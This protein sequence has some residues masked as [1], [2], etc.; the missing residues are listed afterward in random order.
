L[1]EHYSWRK[2][3]GAVPAPETP[4]VTERLVSVR[5]LMRFGGCLL[6]TALTVGAAY[7]IPAGAA[8]VPEAK[9]AATGDLI[10][11]PAQS[12][13]LTLITGDRFIV[14][15]DGLSVTPVPVPG[16]E[17]MQYLTERSGG[18]LTV[19]PV[20][21]VPLV[22]AGTVD[23]RLF[24]VTALMQA[25]HDDSRSALPLIVSYGGGARGEQK[26]RTMVA[27]GEAEVVHELPSIGGIAVRQDQAQL[28]ELW[29]AL[30]RPAAAVSTLALEAGVTRVA[31][32]GVDEL[33]LDASVP[34]IGAPAL[35]ADGFTGKGVKIGLIDSGIDPNHPDLAGRVVAQDFTGTGLQDD[36]GHGTHVAST[37]AGN[38]AASGGRYKGVAPDATIYSAKACTLGGCTESAILRS[39]EWLSTVE[40]LPVVNM[41]LGLRDRLGLDNVETAVQNLSAANGT[42]FVIAAGNDGEEGLPVGSPAS[43][44]DA[45]AVGSVSKQDVPSVF[46]NGGPR[47]GDGVFKPEIVAPG[48]AIT[49]ARS[50]LME[51]GSGQYVTL[52]G[53]S[54]A[55]PHVAASAALLAQQHPDW[56][57]AE[58]KS[59]LMA[60]AAPVDH[61]TAYQVGAGRVDI[62]RA[63]KQTVTTSPPAVTFGDGGGTAPIT[64]TVTYT[65]AGTADITLDLTLDVHG[66]NGEAAPAGMLTLAA[67]SI[68]VPAGGRASVDVTGERGDSPPGAYGGWIVA[69]S[70][71]ERVINT[72]IGLPPQGYDLTIRLL[73]RA[74]GMPRVARLVIVNMDSG[75]VEWHPDFV[76]DSVVTHLPP[77]R[78]LV[79]VAMQELD[80]AQLTMLSYP[81][82]SVTDA[83]TVQMDAR[84]AKPIDLSI[85]K[86]GAVL[87]TGH[88]NVTATVGD[89]ETLAYGISG[90]LASMFTGQVGTGSDEGIES[91]ISAY[92]A[93]RQP[94]GGVDNS[95]WTAAVALT[96]PGTL[97]GY[98]RVVQDEE[99]ATVQSSFARSSVNDADVVKVNVPTWPDFGADEWGGAIISD[100]PTG[101]TDYYASEGDAGWDVDVMNDVAGIFP[102][103]PAIKVP[104]QTF[105]TDGNTYQAGQTYDEAWNTGVFGPGFPVQVDAVQSGLTR[106]GNRLVVG[107]TMFSDDQLRLASSSTVGQFG[108]VT[109]DGVVLTEGAAVGTDLTVPAADAEYKVLINTGRHPAVTTSTSNQVTWTFRSAE[110]PAGTLTRLPVSVVRFLPE[111]DINNKAP[112]GDYELIP[113]MVQRQPGAAS[114]STSEFEL[115]VSYDDGVTWL[116]PVIERFGDFGVALMKR[117]T[118]MT[119]G[120]ASLQSKATMSDGG[121]VEQ[122]IIRAIRF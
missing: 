32:D 49:A 65:N 17:G 90:T 80:G 55:T 112:I 57:F 111:L 122:R 121:T 99:F 88:V 96:A 98:T 39:M 102:T 72:A 67:D 82:L 66:P 78:Y 113:F 105:S 73:S 94:G 70:G 95:P 86:P 45:L 54:M 23:D 109:R 68:T 74:G 31:L 71:G 84:I 10:A 100:L 101:R 2:G 52:D 64:K 41:S 25:G 5:P 4:N 1:I 11:A 12:H 77:G 108:R 110:T 20:D 43:A 87:V 53:T 69:R 13:T 40:K 44:D 48:E 60:G 29:E 106:S 117:P 85:T 24:D 35:W 26:V 76:G 79:S 51:I 18:H 107:A 56:K 116:Q 104:V 83:T 47:I 93:Q 115:T 15:A 59:A 46:S 62:S 16:R 36:A 9:P 91:R 61:A 30:T 19:L 21:A 75:Q 33:L 6:A 7:A 118:G 114:A 3:V 58:L 120:F 42:L 92:F 81:D 8:Q 63:V 14:S 119:S 50:E 38:G 89:Q 27:A 37:M 28:G 22:N 97:D 34:Q 103:S